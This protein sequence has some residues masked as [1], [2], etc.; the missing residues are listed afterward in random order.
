MPDSHALLDAALAAHADLLA[1]VGRE[2]REET[3]AAGR[4]LAA[5]LVRGG[6]ILVC[7]NGGSAADAQHFAAEMVGRFGREG[8][9][10]P[11]IALVADGAVLTAL[12]NDDGFE[13]VFATQVRALGRAG[14]TLLVI[15]TSGRS[16]NVVRAA[17]TARDR[18]LAVVALTGADGLAGDG[19]AEVTLAV[20][21]R[22]TQRIQEMHSVLL[23]CLGEMALA[24]R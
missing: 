7:G 11:A 20:P 12:A 16:T 1:R 24:A 14:D 4:L 17:A 3:V 19:A 2:L 5:T 21:S 23:H 13:Q 8:E 10:L 22:D 15:S 9:P 18:G 6:S